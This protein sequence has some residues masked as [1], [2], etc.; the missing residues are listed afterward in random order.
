MPSVSESIEGPL[1]Q[2]RTLT[3]EESHSV[4]PG[5]IQEGNVCQQESIASIQQILQGQ[6]QQK[7][8]AFSMLAHEI[9][10]PLTCLSA[11]VD[12]LRDT[13]LNEEQKELVGHLA[14]CCTQLMS[15]V[16]NVLDDQERSTTTI[17]PAIERFTVESLLHHGQLLL[18]PFA[19]KKEIKLTCQMEEERGILVEGDRSSLIQVITN[20]GTNAIKFTP[21]GGEV[22]LRASLEAM[23][24]AAAWSLKIEVSDTG[25]GI[26][27]V[28]RG[29]LFQRFTQANSSV[30]RKF[31]G[32]GLGLWICK[33]IIEDRMNGHIGI[34]HDQMQPKVGSTF[35]F[36]VCLKASSISSAPR[37]TSRQS[38]SSASLS[39]SN[40]SLFESRASSS[41][42]P[43]LFPTPTLAALTETSP[44]ASTDSVTDSACPVHRPGYYTLPSDLS[45][46]YSGSHSSGGGNCSTQ[47]SPDSLHTLSRFGQHSLLLVEDCP[48]SGMLM[49]AQLRSMGLQDITIAKTGRQAQRM[50][51]ARP[52][53]VVLTD[54]HV[55]TA[56]DAVQGPELVS[57]LRSYQ[58]SHRPDMPLVVGGIT[59]DSRVQQWTGVD[60]ILQKPFDRRTLG[61]FLSHLLSFLPD[62]QATTRRP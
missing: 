38:E 53:S 10:T 18:M 13:A 43:V 51:A 11:V 27:E 55:G 46:G 23:N 9:R 48:V 61:S 60:R 40:A 29:K 25:P 52:F 44:D 5:E 28:A 8:D 30:K 35:W 47:L 37:C 41:F 34:M 12:L 17:P 32:S 56:A 6:L 21:V 16:N 54:Y 31:G 45:L 19:M 59:G 49:A 57:L 42:S 1:P 3:P 50:F 58:C 39:R 4:V 33:T 62:G 26:S 15:N 20:L 14:A 36:E 24:G 7:E 2:E 22:S